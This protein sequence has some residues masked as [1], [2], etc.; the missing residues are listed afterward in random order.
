[1]KSIKIVTSNLYEERLE[2]L[3]SVRSIHNLTSFVM[4]SGADVFV[5]HLKAAAERGAKVQVLL[6]II[7]LSLNQKH[8]K[9]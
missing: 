9:D 1:M 8:L 6:V 2:G 5:P 7:Y 4:K 3:Q